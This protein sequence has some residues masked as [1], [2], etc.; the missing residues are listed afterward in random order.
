MHENNKKVVVIGGGVAGLSAGIYALRLGYPVELFEKNAVPGGECT[1]WDRDGYHI[2]NCIHWLMGTTPGSDLHD[3]YRETRF[4]DDSTGVLRSDVMYTSWLNG[5]RLSLYS[6]LDKTRKEWIALSPEDK[7]EINTLFDNVALGTSTLIPAGIPGEQL[8]AIG[9]TRL[10]LKSLKMFRLF[11][12]YPR[13]STQDLMN[14]FKHPLI[15]RCLSDFCPRESKAY[16]F[17]VAYGNFVS[18]DG[19]LLVGGSRAAALRMKARFEEL[20][21]AYRG[22]APVRHIEVAGDRATG[23][24]LEGGTHVKADYVIPACDA[25]F[26]FSQLLDR[27][28]MPEKLREYFD[29]PDIY[30]I[31]GMFQAA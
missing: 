3:L 2:D 24:V 8:G 6:D 9:G 27:S 4:I 22:S 29:K 5:Q 31:Y 15:Q 30:P 20:G 11:M 1:G 25:D 7:D 16:S 18:G 28:Y 17:P 19:G 14:K 12:R 26:T 21:G 13:E 10:F 23:I